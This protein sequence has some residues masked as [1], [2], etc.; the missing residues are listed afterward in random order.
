MLLFNACEQP[1]QLF[2]ANAGN[3]NPS[4]RIATSSKLIPLNRILIMERY[5]NITLHFLM[6]FFFKHFCLR[7]AYANIAPNYEANEGKL[8]FEFTF[9]Y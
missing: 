6:V 4:I 8:H 2:I 7:F 1:E 5:Q 3:F 9:T